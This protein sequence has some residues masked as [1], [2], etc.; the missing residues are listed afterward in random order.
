VYSVN[1][2][3]PHSVGSRMNRSDATGTAA[4][5]DVVS[6]LVEFK[7][8]FSQEANMRATRMDHTQFSFS[9]MEQRQTNHV[10][11]NCGVRRIDDRLHKKT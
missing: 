10:R 8:E 9:L 11:K 5:Y 3:D 6:C 7:C 4:S 2:E 1:D